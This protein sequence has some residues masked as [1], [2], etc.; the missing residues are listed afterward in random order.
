MFI[1]IS[2][3]KCVQSGDQKASHRS[4]EGNPEK[5]SNEEEINKDVHKKLF[6]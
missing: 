2:S 6:K 5:K 4:G 1:R 3:F